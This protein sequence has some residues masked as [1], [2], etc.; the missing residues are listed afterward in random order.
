MEQHII[1]EIVNG[2][3]VKAVG[4]VVGFLVVQAILGY[5]FI[6]RGIKSLISEVAEMR[7]QIIENLTATNRLVEMHNEPDRYGFGV[8][9]VR[10]EIRDLMEEIKRQNEIL[11]EQTKYLIRLITL[12]EKNGFSQR[13]AL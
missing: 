3:L 6:I 8:K 5:V 13:G 11:Q 12:I 10:S 2:L 4:A 7:P 1:N 9:G